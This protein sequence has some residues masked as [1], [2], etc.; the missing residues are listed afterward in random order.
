[1]ATVNITAQRLREILHY[2]PD[3][4]IFRYL[5]KRGTCAPGSIAGSVMLRGNWSMGLEYGR[6]SAHRLAWLYMTGEWPALEVDHIDGNPVNN[7]WDN[8][9]LATS[10]Q[11]KQNQHRP[12]SDNTSG[13]LG[14]FLH[15]FARDGSKRWRARIQIDGKGKHLGLFKSPELAYSAYLKAKRQ[16]HPFGNL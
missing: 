4:G 9:R 11:N 3:T 16:I 6:Y 5:V 10:A 1:M 8:L 15:G 12:R 7:R 13:Y 14:V 2:D